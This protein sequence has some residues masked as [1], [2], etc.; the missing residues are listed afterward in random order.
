MLLLIGH[1]F[2]KPFIIHKHYDP[3]IV[4]YKEQRLSSHFTSIQQH[5]PKIGGIYGLIPGD[6]NKA[7]FI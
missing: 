6:K 3:F 1:L 7:L 5:H 4:Y 2:E